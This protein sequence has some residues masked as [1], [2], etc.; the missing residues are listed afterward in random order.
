VTPAAPR[1]RALERVAAIDCGTNSLR[2]LVAEVDGD[3]LVD[4]HRLTRIVRLGEGVDATGAIA[5]QALARTLAVTAEYAQLCRDAGVARLRMVAT[6]A[7][8]DARNAAEFADAVRALLGVDPQVVSGDE[9]ARLSFAG[10]VGGLPPEA[11]AG[12][13]LVVDLGGGSTELVL[14]DPHEPDGVRAAVSVDV[15]SV[16]ITERHLAGDPPTA[17]ELAAA[18]ADVAAALDRAADVVDVTQARSLVGVAGTITTVTAHAL[19][20][21]AYDPARVHGAVLPVPVVREACADLVRLPRERR[22]ALPYLDPGRADVI[23][24]GALIWDLVVERVSRAA[25]LQEV[26]TSERDILD[27]ICRALARA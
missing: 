14:G 20:L 17:S 27:G 15:G 4:V 24:A 9:E 25:G 12:P 13:C 16:R 3:R 8:R 7:S 1:R 11:V 10:A 2:L 23:G 6:S 5:P 22:A 18:R 19:R 21:P 26:L